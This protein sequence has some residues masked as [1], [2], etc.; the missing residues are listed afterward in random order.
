MIRNGEMA[1]MVER[2]RACTLEGRK[3]M[4]AQSKPQQQGVLEGSRP[5]MVVDSEQV[6]W[7]KEL[8]R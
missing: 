3:D 5:K 8:K 6:G 1:Q 4:R 7:P 2:R